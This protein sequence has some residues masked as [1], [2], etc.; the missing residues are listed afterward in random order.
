MSGIYA[1]GGTLRLLVRARRRRRRPRRDRGGGERRDR[2]ASST[3][4]I[5][6]STRRSRTR[7]ASRSRSRPWST[8][9]T[10]CAPTPSGPLDAVRLPLVAL[11]IVLLVVGLVLMVRGRRSPTPA[12]ATSGC[13]DAQGVE[14]AGETSGGDTVQD[15]RLGIRRR[16]PH[17]PWP[18]SIP[19]A[20]AERRTPRPVEAADEPSTPAPLAHEPPARSEGTPS[21]RSQAANDRRTRPRQ[22]QAARCSAGRR[23]P[24]LPRR[25]SRRARPTDEMGPAPMTPDREAAIR[26]MLEDQLEQLRT[27]SRRRKTPPSTRIGAAGRTRCRNSPCAP[28]RRLA[29]GAPGWQ[30]PS[31]GPADQDMIERAAQSSRPSWRRRKPLRPRPWRTPMSS[32][33]RSTRL[34]RVARRRSIRIGCAACASWPPP[35]S[36]RRSP[37]PRRRGRAARG[38]DRV[39]PRGAGGSGRSARREGGR[40]GAAGDRARDPAAGGQRRRRRRSGRDRHPDRRA[41][42]RE[43]PR[44]GAGIR[45]QRP[46]VRT[47]ARQA[48]PR[49]RGCGP[50]LRVTW[51]EPSRQRTVSPRSKPTFWPPRQAST[52]SSILSRT[53]TLNCRRRVRRRPRRCGSHR[54]RP[55]PNRRSMPRSST[56]STPRSRTRSMPKS[57]T[58]STPRSQTSR[59]P[60][61]SRPAH[62]GLLLGRTRRSRKRTAPRRVRSSG[63]RS[64]TVTG[65]PRSSPPRSRKIIPRT[66]ASRRASGRL[67]PKLPVA[68]ADLPQAP[69]A[70]DRYGDVWSESRPSRIRP[71]RPHQ[72]RQSP[73]SKASAA[74]APAE[75]APQSSA[76]MAS[77]LDESDPAQEE[78]S[79]PRSERTR[80]RTERR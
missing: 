51:S 15:E 49:S 19:P 2:A 1:L 5:W 72:R 76:P 59:R 6:R 12:V 39:C 65:S 64:R 62:P 78:P 38:I 43:R 54:V 48:P 27:R 8:T 63:R 40:T 61:R 29:A 14:E 10:P 41:R 23:G 20:D 36:G 73:Q 21:E 50:S 56:R 55:H 26:R 35:S 30:P 44:R 45:R 70:D 33:A 74:P 24:R 77:S 32:N 71:Q 34:A 58:K 79:E 28:R 69:A 3:G 46:P 53:R 31:V 60:P 9:S 52:R 22:D 66:E 13:G 68:H 75:T 17:S 25:P 80:R 16:A 47:T 42:A 18:R 37:A 11:G 4:R 7:A 57:R 67:S